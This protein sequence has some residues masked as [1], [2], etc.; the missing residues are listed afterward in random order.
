MKL[1][2]L[3]PSE[4]KKILIYGLSG[5][6]KTVFATG[7]P[8]PVFVMDFDG[9]VSSA[10]S[11]WKG[12]S[13]LDQIEFES[14]AGKADFSKFWT[15]FQELLKLGK[16]GQLPYRT[17]VLDSI[18]TFSASLMNEVMRQN[19]GDEGKRSRV[20]DTTV[21]HL[22]DYQ[23]AIS[24]FKNTVAQLLSLP[25]NVVVTAHLQIDKDEMTG[26]ILRQPLI[27]GKDLPGW[28]PMVFEEVYYASVIAGKDN[29]AEHQAQARGPKYVCRTQIPAL[30]ATFKLGYEE[31]KKF[32]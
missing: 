4:N 20:S 11:Y 9:K 15:K 19:P 13:Q 24:H 29:K 25:C 6:G 3:N 21:P 5:A 8:G 12:S 17:V 23:I 32:L 1:S 31:L 30:P 7:F 18:T 10:A 28:L 14:Y 26:E 27:F 16:A 2:E 22:K